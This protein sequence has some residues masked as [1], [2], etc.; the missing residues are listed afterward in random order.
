MTSAS[1]AIAYNNGELVEPGVALVM[2]TMAGYSAYFTANDPR[3][4]CRRCICIFIDQYN[5]ALVTNYRIFSMPYYQ[6][7]AY[8]SHT[9]SE[10]DAMYYADSNSTGVHIG[11][12]MLEVCYSRT[13][14]HFG[15]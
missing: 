7:T 9:Y 10:A 13:S 6:W 4:V 14:Y 8:S 1:D 5:F 2:E 11:F 3:L 12:P 15:M